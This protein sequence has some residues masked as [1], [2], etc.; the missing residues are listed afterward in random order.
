MGNILTFIELVA[1]AFWLGG[2]GVPR[3]IGFANARLPVA[4]VCALTLALVQAGRGFLW[5]WSGMTTPACAL[6]A[7]LSALGIWRP[8]LISGPAALLPLLA[9]TAWIAMRGW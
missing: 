2:I 9:Y 7:I 4:L 3:T 1:L 5:T 6:F 8:R